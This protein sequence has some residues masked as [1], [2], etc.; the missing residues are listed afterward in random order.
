M[1]SADQLMRV[2]VVVALEHGHYL[3]SFLE[4]LAN[5]DGVIHRVRPFDVESLMNE[6]EGRFVGPV[7]VLTQP[8]E[9]MSRNV[10]VRPLEVPVA[11]GYSV[12][13]IAAESSNRPS[14]SVRPKPPAPTSSPAVEKATSAPSTG[15]P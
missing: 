15:W 10:G 12:R 3:I 2:Q 9:L 11:V 13:A 4:N 1:Y 7:E 8:L 6:H 14:S 5:L